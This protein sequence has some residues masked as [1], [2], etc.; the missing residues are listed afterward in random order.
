MRHLTWLLGA[1]LAL[2]ALAD[3]ATLTWPLPTTWSDGTPLNPLSVQWTN[4]Y[5]S[6][7]P[8]SDT[9]AGD[10]MTSVQGQGTCYTFAFSATTYCRIGIVAGTPGALD[11]EEGTLSDPVRIDPLPTTHTSTVTGVVKGARPLQCTTTTVCKLL[12]GG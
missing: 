8:F 6:S 10:W 7:T 1:L 9:N 4:V 2:P 12:K 11:G 5:C 3:V